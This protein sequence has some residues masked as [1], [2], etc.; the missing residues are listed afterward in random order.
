MVAVTGSEFT[1]NSATYG[2]AILVYGG[3][4]DT[5]DDLITGNSAAIAG[6]G[7]WVG[8][9]GTLNLDAGTVVSGN[10]APTDPDIS[11]N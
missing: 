9:G 1:S 8:G 7:I 11:Y 6:G 3:T 5:G 10:S 4:L 2:G